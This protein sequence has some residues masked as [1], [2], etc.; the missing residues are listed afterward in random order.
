MPE[1]QGG[2]LG[3]P[4]IQGVTSLGR[5]RAPRAGQSG[6]SADTPW[7]GVWALGCFWRAGGDGFYRQMSS[8]TGD[9]KFLALLYFK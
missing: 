3:A 8:G 5:P 9:N 1:G 7:A 4:R 2:V 6:S